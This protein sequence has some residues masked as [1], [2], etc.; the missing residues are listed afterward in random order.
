VESPTIDFTVIVK[1]NS[2]SGKAIP[3]A[4]VYAY[5]PS[6]DSMGLYGQTDAMGQ[7]KFKTKAG[8]YT[9]GAYIEGLPTPAEQTITIGSSGAY[10]GTLVV[11]MPNRTIA[12]KLLNGNNPISGVNIS[13]YNE[14]KGVYLNTMTDSA[15]DFKFYVEDGTWRLGGWVQTYGPLTEK[16]LTVA[17]ES[18]SNQNFVISQEGVY[19]MTGS[20]NLGSASGTG[21]SGVNIFAESTDNDYTKNFF[22][23]TDT[24]GAFN[25]SL[26]DGSYILHAY[27]P[28]YGE[29]GTKTKTVAGANSSAGAFVIESQKTVTVTM[30]GAGLPNDLL[31][32][33]WMVDV[34]D[35]VNKKGFSKKIKSLTGYTFENVGA[36]TYDV[37]VNIVGMGQVFGSG[38]FVVDSGKTIDIV[39]YEAEQLVSLA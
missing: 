12:G 35:T 32:F 23:F 38:S 33:E 24:A 27:H 31:K 14:M 4:N 39:L 22:A 15:G 20:V 18:L 21:V 7:V 5:S 34:F 13:A 1:D 19:S 37:K 16:T 26:K 29:V 36:G 3:K 2:A 17:G 6:G 11:I 10:T 28:Q 25:L 30:T 8:V 9:Y